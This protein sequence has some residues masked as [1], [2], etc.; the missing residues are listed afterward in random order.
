MYL[1]IVFSLQEL[2]KSVYFNWL[3]FY[4]EYYETISIILNNWAPPLVLSQTTTRPAATFRFRAS[5]VLL[6]EQLLKSNHGPCSKEVNKMKAN[7]NSNNWRHLTAQFAD[8]LF[9]YLLPF[10]IAHFHCTCNKI[11]LQWDKQGN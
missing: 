11:N 9:P 4:Y 7:N 5:K 1:K 8:Q 6:Q 2:E 3:L 10:Y